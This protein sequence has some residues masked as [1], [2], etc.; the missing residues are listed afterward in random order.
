M[1]LAANAASAS[2]GE[3]PALPLP[4]GPAGIPLLGPLRGRRSR[5]S[6][7]DRRVRRL[8]PDRGE[9]GERDV[10]ALEEPLR[11]RRPW[12]HAPSLPARALISPSAP[13][14]ARH[15]PVRRDAPPAARSRAVSTR[16]RDAPA[17]A[18]GSEPSFAR[19]GSGAAAR[20][21]GVS[22]PAARV[23]RI[24]R[25]AAPRR[26]G[27]RRARLRRP[28]RAGDEYAARRV[29]DSSR[30]VRRGSHPERRPRASTT[31]RGKPFAFRTTG[32]SRA[33]TSRGAMPTPA[34]SPGAARA[35]IERPSSS[36][37]PTPA[38]GST[39][40]SMA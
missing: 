35:G 7:L 30:L 32:R 19:H 9:R 15:P 14:R 25:A 23:V 26:S 21:Q 10:H 38:A 24:R 11:S 22:R 18:A 39:S 6:S 29:G 12:A 3:E 8:L 37:P 5:E 17:A 4:D 27:R 31:P 34:S 36:A 1:V 33:P 13:A 28:R 20:R 40:T 2:P 16:G